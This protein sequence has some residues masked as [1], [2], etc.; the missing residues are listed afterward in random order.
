[1]EQKKIFRYLKY[2]TVT[3]LAVLTGF[4]SLLVLSVLTLRW[5]DPF[6][7]SFILQ[8]KWVELETERYNLRDWWVPDSELPDHLKWA[9][10]ASED[11][12]FYE[13]H[14]FDIEAIKEALEERREGRRNR[15]ASTI[16]QQTAKNL[17]LWPEPSFFRKGIEAFITLL[18][19]FFWTKDRILE[20]Y[21]NIAE[22]GPGLFGAGKA[23]DVLF[24]VNP[25][26]LEPEMSARLAAVLPSPRRMRVEPPSPFALERSRWVLRQMT[27]LSG[28]AYLPADTLEQIDEID[29]FTG[30]SLSILLEE[31]SQS[32]SRTDSV[33]I[34]SGPDSIFLNNNSDTLIRT[35]NNDTLPAITDTIP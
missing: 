25:S 30:D 14:G 11:Q 35:I 20:V 18:I 31:A 26:Q 10:I 23:S 16:T 32:V 24:S 27:Q 28:I 13:H 21:L 34:Q 6:T 19:E 22:F 4:V 1:M 17:Y 5:T 3:V 2:I 8:E 29:P 9:V 12:L 15:G 7:T 33:N